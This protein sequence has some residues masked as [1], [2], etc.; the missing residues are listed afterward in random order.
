[1]GALDSPEISDK[2][3]LI[4]EIHKAGFQV[5][6]YILRHGLTEEQAL[7]IESA[8]ID[9]LG[10]DNLTNEVKGHQSWERGLIL[11]EAN[12]NALCRADEVIQFYDAKVITM[13]EPAV[14][15]NI[16]KTYKRFMTEPELYD[17]TRAS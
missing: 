7:E 2:L 13:T 17:V 5:E 15:I 8:C 6:H 14:I 16:N 9:L 4:R 12:A 3:D 11:I 1:M 10:L